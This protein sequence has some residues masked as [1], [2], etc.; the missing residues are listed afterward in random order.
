M[1]D[2][3]TPSYPRQPAPT[4]IVLKGGTKKGKCI[5]T[6]VSPPVYLVRSDLSSSDLAITLNIIIG[7]D[8]M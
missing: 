1:G 8:E 5:R 2:L 4:L 7:D 6:D 3:Q